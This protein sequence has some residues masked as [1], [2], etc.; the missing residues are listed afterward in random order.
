MKKVLSD[1][2]KSKEEFERFCNLFLKKEVSPFVKVYYAQGRDGGIDADYTG[3]YTQKD[4]TWIFQYKFFDPTM[5]KGRARSQLI[6]KMKGEL[7]KADAL[8][9]DHYILMTNTLLTAG[10]KRKIEDIKNEKGY[11]FSLTCWDAE[12]LITMTDE[13]PYLL[14]SFRDP[15]L[16][17]FLAWPDMF[18]N[19]ITGQNRL[20]RY[21]YDIFG[22]EDEINQ[23]QTFVQDPEKRLFMVYGSGGIGKTKLAIEFAKVI[24]RDHTDYEPLFVQMA[25]DS[26]ESALIDIPP[27]RK[28]IFF[29]DDAHNSIGNL[30]NLKALLKSQEYRKSKV[31]VVTRKPFK[32][33][34][35]GNFIFD[36]PHGTIDEQEIFK[37]SWEK[38]REFIQTHTK[39]PIPVGNQLQHLTALGQDTPLIAVMVIEFHNRGSDLRTLTNDEFLQYAFESYLNDIFSKHLPESDNLH[40]KLLN[41]L[42][43]IAPINAEDV[44]VR[45]K[46][47][48]ITNIEP[49][50]IEQYRADLI[51]Y[52]LLVQT[53]QT[54]RLFPDPLSDYV[55][56]KACFVSEGVPS[57]FHEGL[58][59]EFLSILPTNVI[60]NLARLEN[61][62]NEKSLLDEYVASLKAQTREGDNT[63][64]I[65][66]LEQ[67]EGICY[68]R[69]D[70]AIDIF[71]I[72]M[73]T[74][75]DED[76]E[77][78]EN[79][80][81]GYMLTHQVLTRVIAEKLNQISNYTLQSFRKTLE[82]IRKLI[83]ADNKLE[84]PFYESQAKLLTELT[85][86]QIGKSLLYQQEVLKVFEEW[87]KEDERNL[88]LL[89]LGSLNSLF[90]LHY[91]EPV[92]ESE[93][94]EVVRHHFEYM[95][96]MEELVIQAIDL[97]E[98]CL[99][100]SQ[101]N[102]VR[103]KAIQF[104][105]SAIDHCLNPDVWNSME[106]R[107]RSVKQ[108]RLF[109]ILS[110]QISK[111]FD[112]TVLNEIALCIRKCAENLPRFQKA[113]Q[114]KIQQL[115]VKFR[116]YNDFRPNLPHLL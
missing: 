25:K 6:F 21:D 109:E 60:T 64:R 48:E 111:E 85:R 26:F 84:L 2:I 8:Q 5:D 19:Q 11:T 54:E 102:I 41:W 87:R 71:N 62:T 57:S 37:L 100:T 88:S 112:D 51:K 59:K 99:N 77:F 24:E 32:E 40:R 80:N 13:F 114:E 74:P 113:Q 81:D 9:C 45:D 90:E 89:M 22:R 98:N 66:V 17:V 83:L 105:S 101:H 3:Y 68:F 23:F 110:N 91:Y 55:L 78:I 103:R 29:I 28:Y 47:S 20:L 46:L 93:A 27:N 12:D 107:E 50:E 56:R 72:I 67:M 18:Q 94:L 49:Y 65:D 42:S 15:Y 76:S 16:P 36:L 14:N 43:G 97:A 92:N 61:I 69:P 33:I 108:N 4:G 82:I 53:G 106:E 116:K 79:R 104:I 58:L 34:V 35:K 52:G 7:D 39:E 95:P 75:N 38:T 63:F 44:R 86:F 70:D 115:V 96:E 10:N 30:E 73:D 1:Y 31:V